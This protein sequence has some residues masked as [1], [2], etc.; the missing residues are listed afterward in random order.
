MSMRIVLI[1]PSR[2]CLVHPHAHPPLG[3]LYIAAVLRESGH[4][5]RYRDL[6]PR[7]DI[8]DADLYGVSASVGDAGELESIARR[9]RRRPGKTVIGGAYVTATRDK[10]LFDA[11]VIGE[12]ER[13]ILGLIRDY[14]D[15]EPY[16]SAPDIADLDTLPLPARDMLEHLGSDRWLVDDGR[17]SATLVTSR[18]CP[19]RC[20]FCGSHAQWSRK[21]RYRSAGNVLAEVEHVISEYGV[22]AFRIHDDQFVLN[23]PRLDALLEGFERLGITWRAS[24]RVDSVTGP[25]LRD[26]ARAG[27]VELSY[28]VEA[29]DQ[30]VLDAI[31]K[32]ITVAQCGDALRWTQEAG[33]R[34]RVLLMCGLPGE[35]PHTPDRTIAFLEETRSQWS[36][37]S[38]TEYVPL[39]GTPMWESP[40][41]FGMTIQRREPPRSWYLFTE[42]GLSGI[43]DMVAVDGMSMAALRRN[44][45]RLRDYVLSTDKAN[46]G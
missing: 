10:G 42:T 44:K 23:R 30:A 32:G 43:H 5:V 27:C 11:A 40:R 14:P 46:T 35:T 34:A 36:T 19:F 3:V 38:L 41:R 15:L 16:Y 6:T 25:L 45:E 18:G 24:V 26:M 2:R 13:A 7:D 39:P 21:V 28:G 31:H 1:S 37:V 9:L 33:I 22:T 17:P 20:G 12:G 8:P 29:A 4:E